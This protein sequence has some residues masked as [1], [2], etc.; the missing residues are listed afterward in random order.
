[1]D[2][3]HSHG[4]GDANHLRNQAGEARMRTRLVAVL[5]LVA[6]YMVVEAVAGWLTNSLALLADAGHMLTDAGAIGLALFA[7]SLA[8]RPSNPRK[9][10]GYYRAEILAALANAVTLILIVVGISWEAYRRLL[11]PPP[12]MGMPMML[13][14]AAGLAVNVVAMRVLDVDKDTHS[15]NVQ[16]VFWH[17]IGDAL[18]SVGAVTA[19]LLM[20][21]KG[22]FW[23][24]PLAS[25]AISVI[26]LL[27]AVRLTRDS[28]NVLMEGTP[29][30]L[31]A[32]EVEAALAAL[33]GVVAVHD[34]HV[35]TV[36]SNY[37]SLSVHLIVDD[38][39]DV[40][41]VLSA[42]RAMLRERF[43]IDHVTIQ[44]EPSDFVGCECA[45]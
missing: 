4:H 27:G 15:L 44:I 32:E 8:R 29:E 20:W 7:A 23:A 43:G 12:V 5:V 42:A 33:P 38:A 37:E 26:I 6:G 40:A 34:L 16:G 9:S 35:W 11:H 28:V 2:H 1:M 45:F 17:I 10:Y 25:A 24:D 22:W 30:R 3:H 19:G 13:V 18:G 39:A 21:W 36:T 31:A 41:E 14:A